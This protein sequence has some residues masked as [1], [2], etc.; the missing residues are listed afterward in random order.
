MKE[1]EREHLAFQDLV[2]DDD[3]MIAKLRSQI[4]SL[5]KQDSEQASTITSLRS[6]IC[7][8]NEKVAQLSSEIVQVS[9]NGHTN[10]RERAFLKTKL[11]NS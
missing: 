7:Q 6:E 8:L 2:I 3:T 9:S 5:L 10:E 1:N 11:R 4:Q